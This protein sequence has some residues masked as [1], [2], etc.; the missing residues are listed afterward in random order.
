[1]GTEIDEL[2]LV[3]YLMVDFPSGQSNFTGEMAR[4]LSRLDE[5]P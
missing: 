5:S 4:E 1:M 3:D 2:A